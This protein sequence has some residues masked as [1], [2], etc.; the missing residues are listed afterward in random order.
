VTQEKY[1][2]FLGASNTFG[3]GLHTFREVYM[4]EEGANKLRWP[5]NQSPQHDNPFIYE[6][7]WTNIVSNYINRKEINIAE[8]GGSPAESLHRLEVYEP[9]TNIDYIFFEFSAIYHYFDKYLHNSQYPKTPR[10]IERFLTNGKNDRPELR[11]RIINWLINYNAE[12]FTNEVLTTL[13]NKLETLTDKKVIILLW[14]DCRIDVESAEHSW[15]KKYLVKFPTQ[16]DENNYVVHNL[17]EE[18]KLRVMDEYPFF[19]I[20]QRNYPETEDIHAGL[21]GNKLVANIIINHL[22]E[23]KLIDSW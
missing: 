15:L 9:L 4:S 1:A 10:E 6:N 2:L 23:K 3:V 13:K 21:E 20:L 19:H 22:N 5:Y 7:R 14:R 12:E 8:A 11:E 18:R 17:I 16:Q